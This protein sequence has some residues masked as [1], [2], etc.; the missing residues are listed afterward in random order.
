MI[1]KLVVL[2]F[3]LLFI[4]S[5]NAQFLTEGAID[6]EAYRGAQP[7]II[8]GVSVED[9]IGNP[10]VR[11]L[12]FV[13]SNILGLTIDEKAVI[14][15]GLLP[16]VPHKSDSVVLGRVG[17][18]MRLA[19]VLGVAPFIKEENKNDSLVNVERFVYRNGKKYGWL[20]GKEAKMYWPGEKLVGVEL[21]T[22][23]ISVLENIVCTSTNDN[24]FEGKVNPINIYRKSIPHESARVGPGYHH[25][26]GVRHHIFLE[27]EKPFQEGKSY[28]IQFESD[29]NIE[30]D[31]SFTVD[32]K[33]HRS[34][35][36]QVNL[37]GY[38]PMQKPKMAYLSMWLGDGGEVDYSEYKSFK[39]IDCESNNSVYSGEIILRSSADNI[40]THIHDRF[41]PDNYEKTNVY[42][43]EFSDFQTPGKYKIYIPG[44]GVSFPFVID[45]D[46]YLNSFKVQMRGFLHNRSGIEMK[47]PY[48]TYI[49][50]RNMHPDDGHLTYN[51][52]KEVFY[53]ESLYKGYAPIHANPFQRIG[54]SIRLDSHNE[55]AWGGW[56]D[57][58]DYDRRYNHL[59]ASH[60]LLE[61]YE[62]NPEF[63][64]NMDL[65]IPESGNDLPD[66]IDE[67]R[68]GMDLWK[69]TQTDEGEIFYG[70]ETISHPSGGESS[71]NESLPAAL[72]PGAP[73]IA[74][75]YAATAAHMGIVLKDFDS[76]LSQEYIESAIKA[77]NWADKNKDNP[78]YEKAPQPVAYMQCDLAAFLYEAT[79]DKK[80]NDRFI[81]NYDLIKNDPHF[82][83][84]QM[85]FRGMVRYL[86]LNE[87]GLKTDK[88]SVKSITN[89]L[90]ERCDELIALGEKMAY[91]EFED[92]D[93]GRWFVVLDN[94]P[95]LI[96]AFQ[97]TNDQKYIEAVVEAGHF[98]LGA[99]ALN[100]TFT[101]GIGAR[102]IHQ[103]DAEALFCNVPI[104]TGIG[105]IGPSPY[106]RTRELPDGS[107]FWTKSKKKGI[108]YY[109]Y[110][111]VEEWPVRETYFEQLRFPSVNEF[112]MMQNLADQAYR[113]GFLAWYLKGAQ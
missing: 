95:L 6:Y 21:N 53:D 24:G 101:S 29:I 88:K 32:L 16:Y 55:N 38:P 14:R 12:Y 8:E 44:I 34:E 64:K 48:T 106:P 56:M 98:G 26:D 108:N 102:F 2:P 66:L 51:C 83:L 79:G 87:K 90:F 37:A 75:L 59:E 50:P 74:C 67:A 82:K 41:G 22:D 113:W 33:N 15:S 45:E 27:F 18:Q 13:N 19:E 99:N 97:I 46:T 77:V 86:S 52:D 78:L 105:S 89:L 109:M 23:V 96:S 76:E 4:N 92:F 57:A 60:M 62:S 70:I 42:T 11:H 3:L 7:E 69:R 39:I 73:Y 103:W 85:N 68:W 49:R 30:S 36:I 20:V 35:A 94:S 25:I 112:T 71:W 61:V 100:T 84:F 10:L 65:S 28:S 40:L 91:A 9:A 81:E 72:V 107:F 63:F 5:I 47:L 80:W 104:A 17:A 54:M 31:L 43:M 1:K 111:L 93:W 110:P 58:A